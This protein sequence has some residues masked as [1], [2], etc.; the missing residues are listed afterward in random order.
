MKSP[1]SIEDL[2]VDLEA[3]RDKLFDFP[4]HSNNKTQEV[5]MLELTAVIEKLKLFKNEEKIIPQILSEED[6]PDD[7]DL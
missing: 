1:N 7:E 4:A 5:L 2:V 6:L 3:I